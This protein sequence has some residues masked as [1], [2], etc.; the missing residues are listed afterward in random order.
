[1]LTFVIGGEDEEK[2][3]GEDVGAPGRRQIFLSP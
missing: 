3:A 1:M 2:E